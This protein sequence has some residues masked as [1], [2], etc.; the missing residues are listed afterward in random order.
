[1]RKLFGKLAD[2]IDLEKTYALVK[3]DT[4]VF[5]AD[6]AGATWQPRVTAV[7]QSGG[8]FSGSVRSH[9]LAAALRAAGLPAEVG[10]ESAPGWQLGRLVQRHGFGRLDAVD[11]EPA[12]AVEMVAAA[13]REREERERAAAA[14]RAADLERR[15]RAERQKAR[16]GVAV[17]GD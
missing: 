5:A 4:F 3:A 12:A 11:P 7:G 10:G 15:T 16:F 8:V 9:P 14:A 17:D 13:A 6:A 2:R 1:L